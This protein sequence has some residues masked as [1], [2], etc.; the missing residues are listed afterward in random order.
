MRSSRLASRA[1][2]IVAW[3]CMNGPLMLL[4][5]LPSDQIR[6]LKGKADQVGCA[7]EDGPHVRGSRWVGAIGPPRWQDQGG[8]AGTR[9]AAAGRGLQLAAAV[10]AGS[11]SAAA[12]GGTSSPL[13]KAVTSAS[14]PAAFTAFAPAAAASSAFA[15]PSA[16]SAP[17]PRECQPRR[18]SKRQSLQREG[19]VRLAPIWHLGCTCKGQAVPSMT[20][21]SP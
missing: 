8:C 18:Q 14:I 1:L 16:S 11:P 9:G 4:S 20:L 15:A 10:T 2:P 12:T 7:R 17:S 21:A 13:T 6:G 3:C 5:P 19:V